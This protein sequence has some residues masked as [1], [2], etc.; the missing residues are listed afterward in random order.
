MI[1]LDASSIISSLKSSV[2]LDC[3]ARRFILGTVCM[4]PHSQFKARVQ[5][6]KQPARGKLQAKY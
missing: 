6:Y 4:L 3:A 1:I 2:I 5:W